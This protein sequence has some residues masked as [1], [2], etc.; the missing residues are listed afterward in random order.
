MYALDLH[1]GP[2][3][4]ESLVRGGQGLRSW[5]PRGRD[6]VDPGQEVS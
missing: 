1:P 3:C 2:G 5:C 4:D 6:Q